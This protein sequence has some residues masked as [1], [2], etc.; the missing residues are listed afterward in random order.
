MHD[1]SAGRY[2]L[3]YPQHGV[4]HGEGVHGAAAAARNSAVSAQAAAA[5]GGGPRLHLQGPT[6]RYRRPCERRCLWGLSRSCR[7]RGPDGHELWP[8]LPCTHLRREAISSTQTQSDIHQTSSEADSSMYSPDGHIHSSCNQRTQSRMQSNAITCKH[9]YSLELGIA[10][11]SRPMRSRASLMHLMRE[12]IRRT[13]TQSEA[14]ESPI[15]GARWRFNQTQSEAI[16]AICTFEGVSSSF[17]PAAGVG[18]GH[19]PRRRTSGWVLGSCSRI[20][21]RSM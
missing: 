13:Q 14:I 7:Y 5:S 16:D 10:R 12:A 3:S 9:M 20:R 1:D 6:P 21:C 18:Y 17:R 11:A 15:T 19:E 2:P 4:K 8:T